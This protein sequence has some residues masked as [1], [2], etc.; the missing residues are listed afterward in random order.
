MGACIEQLEVAV[1]LLVREAGDAPDAAAP[2]AAPQGP[3][4]HQ[5]AAPRAPT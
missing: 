1:R 2:P 4:G 5:M 3:T